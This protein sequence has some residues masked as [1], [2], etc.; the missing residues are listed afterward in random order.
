[1]KTSPEE[2]VRG[3]YESTA[4]DYAAMMD[5]EI[6]L[7][8]YTSVLGKLKTKLDNTQGLLID[9][10]CGS[11]HMLWMY[12][13]KFDRSRPLLGVDLS[14]TMVKIARARLGASADVHVGD[15]CRLD[16]VKDATAAGV[17]CFFALHHLDAEGVQAALQEWCRV[18]VPGGQL[19]VATWE[20]DGVIDYGGESE[21]VALRYRDT[22]LSAWVAGAGLTATRCDVQPVQGMPMDAVYL[23]AT[24]SS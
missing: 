14:P 17:I 23:E 1:M 15:M 21:V 13:S 18:L 6:D 5:A 3:L 7:P 24:T 16:M 19:L 10:S 22:D 8:L 11:G 2:Q 12:H 9:S 4:H 20:G